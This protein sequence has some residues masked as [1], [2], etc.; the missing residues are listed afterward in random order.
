MIR[1][2]L[3][4][5]PTQIS[6]LRQAWHSTE[7]SGPSS[8]FTSPEWCQAAWRLLPELGHPRLLIAHDHAEILRAVLPL[9]AASDELVCAGSPLGDEH[10]LRVCPGTH[11]A[12][13][14]RGILASLENYARTEGRVRLRDL[15]ADGVLPRAAD[16]VP[17]SPAPALTLGRAPGEAGGQ[18]A[19]AGVSHKRRKALANRRRALSRLGAVTVD[20]VGEP[21]RLPD[22]VAQFVADR[23]GAWGQR[24]RLQEL[25][26]ADRH[27][28]FAE[29]LATV[30]AALASRGRCFLT[31][32]LL[33]S[34]VVAQ[35]LYF[36]TGRTDL[37]YMTTYEAAFAR[38]SPSHL[39]LAG[40][41]EMA[42]AEGICTI[43]LGRG[44]ERYKFDLGGESR[45]L[46]EVIL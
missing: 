45:H 18:C 31:R 33:D 10:D 28:Q 29:F 25:P 19:S 14:A 8:V 16:T 35:A 13:A 38:Y 20:R 27:P 11:P 44:D 34:R 36:R 4:S 5:D 22:A 23:L 17:G 6:A 32:L 1:T 37:M 21:S 12:N 46:R 42:K 15:R 41:A 40:A 43:E 3:I 2:E 24:G 26:E 30:A 39:L 7:A 9:S